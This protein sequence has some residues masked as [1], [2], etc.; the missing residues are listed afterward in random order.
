MHF[1]PVESCRSLLRMGF[2]AGLFADFA[3]DYEIG[4]LVMAG[5]AI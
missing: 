2:R 5:Y 1:L 3:D 4:R